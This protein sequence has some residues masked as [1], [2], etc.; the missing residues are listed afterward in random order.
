M[1]DTYI[2]FREWLDSVPVIESH[3]HYTGIT[4]PM[5]DPI[6]LIMGNYMNS[7]IDSAAGAE[8][9]KTM[10]ILQN[11]D[12]PF[13]ERYKIFAPLYEKVKHTGYA[14]GTIRGIKEVWGI[15]INLDGI[16]E[17]MGRMDERTTILQNEYID[18]Y[19]IKAAVCDVGTGHILRGETKGMAD[20]CRY[21]IGTFGWHNLHSRNDIYLM[22][23]EFGVS[24]P[25]ASLDDY[26]DAMKNFTKQCVD[27]GFVGIK[28]SSAYRRDLDYKHA[29]RAAAERAFNY[30]LD[31]PRDIIGDDMAR[32][33]DDW[34]FHQIM[35]LARKY[36]LPVQI[37]TGHLAWIR[38]DIQKTNAVQLIKILETYP[39][40]EF[41]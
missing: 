22:A 5:T 13:E 18:K 17:L 16:K 24:V 33:L 20:W 23:E 29:A 12:I 35:Q 27:W 14:K 32:E 6:E 10:R 31:N 30:M 4:E 37:H 21:S 15:D 34:L 9:E 7:D 11:N 36:K 19:N 28:D 25:I 41:D 40:V 26:V 3:E 38:N 8:Y 2:K 39:D 1:N